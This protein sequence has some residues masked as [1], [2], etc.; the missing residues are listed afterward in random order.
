MS[1]MDQL[2]NNQG[3]EP[4]K[5]ICVQDQE[6]LEKEEFNDVNKFYMY[7]MKTLNDFCNPKLLI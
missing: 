7:Q 5:V 6:L 3:N 1:H 4:Y 2:P